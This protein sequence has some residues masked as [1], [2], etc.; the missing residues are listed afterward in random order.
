MSKFVVVLEVSTVMLSSSNFKDFIE[1]QQTYQKRNNYIIIQSVGE[2]D[3][4]LWLSKRG[5]GIY[6]L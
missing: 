5:F 3:K 2:K 1:N 4:R 6:S